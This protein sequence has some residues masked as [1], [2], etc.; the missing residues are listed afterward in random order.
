MSLAFSLLSLFSD[1]SPMW[2]LP[3]EHPQIYVPLG[4]TLKFP[5]CFQ[6][7]RFRLNKYQRCRKKT[8][9]NVKHE[10]HL[11]RETPPGVNPGCHG[12][13]KPH[14]RGPPAVWD[15]QAHAA[16][17]SSPPMSTTRR[18]RGHVCTAEAGHREGRGQE[19][20]ESCSPA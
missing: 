1:C 13:V 5:A 11:Q 2:G 6:G 17:L 16:V 18:P 19:P 3:R 14:G 12:N 9:S 8:F 7:A 4:Q 15:S 10:A 20:R